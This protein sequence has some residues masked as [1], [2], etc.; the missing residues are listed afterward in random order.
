MGGLVR[1]RASVTRI[2]D[3]E[4]RATGVW[5]NNDEFIEADY[6]ICDIHPKEVM[7]LLAD[8]PSVR[9]IYRK[10]IDSLEET[11]GMF[12]ANIRLK[13]NGPVV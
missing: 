3:K 7:R 1:T 11:F 4:G 6:I 5:V 10:R 2:E 13:A 9:K 12:T 8:S